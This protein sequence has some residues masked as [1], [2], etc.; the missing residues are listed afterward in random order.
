ML[1]FSTKG[2]SVTLPGG[3]MAGAH[4]LGFLK[5]LEEENVVVSEFTCVS[6]GSIIGAF[7]TNGYSSKEIGRILVE[8]L[9]TPSLASIFTDLASF[10]SSFMPLMPPIFSP[11]RLFGGGFVD[12]LP[13]MRNLVHKYHLVANEHLQ[14]LAS[15]ARRKPVLFK[16]TDYDLGL[17]L[18]ASC[19]VPGIMRPVTCVIGG[20]KQLLFD[21]GVYHLQPGEFGGPVAIIAKLFDLAFFSDRKGDF[22]TNVGKPDSPV[23]GKLTAQDVEQMQQHGYARARED[24]TAPLRQGLI[25]TCAASF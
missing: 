1:N 15:T 16:G 7:Y 23:F 24:L 25:P 22:I 14:I 2:I 4:L 20:L 3:G 9:S 17:A 10:F 11:L 12:M 8:E 5:F 6:I 13:L 19:A 18:A 21:G